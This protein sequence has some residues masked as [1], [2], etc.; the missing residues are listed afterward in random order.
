[1]RVGGKKEQ[2]N[3]VKPKKGFGVVES[4]DEESDEIKKTNKDLIK[5]SLYKQSYSTDVCEA[6]AEDPT[7]FSYDLYKSKLIEEPKKDQEDQNAKYHN[8]L[9]EIA[10]FKKREREIIKER[11]EAKQRELEKEEFGESEI[12]YTTSYL[13]FMEENKKFEEKLDE[14]DLRSELTSIEHKKPENFLNRII[15][16]R[17][18]EPKKRPKL[19]EESEASEPNTLS[20]LPQSLLQPLKDPSTNQVYS[21]KRTESQ[22]SCAKERYLMRKKTQVHTVVKA[23]PKALSTP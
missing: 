16:D 15:D 7:I 3:V 4:S 23:P 17:D 6:L 19:E 21:D 1:M 14:F 8:H 13:K 10:E 12:Y 5:A 11:V 20:Q 2:K 18:T 9:K 22:L